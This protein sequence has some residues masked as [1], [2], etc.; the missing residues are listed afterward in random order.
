ML[1]SSLSFFTLELLEPF[2]EI[3][4][5][6]SEDAFPG[7]CW[8]FRKPVKPCWKPKSWGADPRRPAWTMDPARRSGL[9]SA[10][11]TQLSRSSRPGPVPAKPKHGCD[12]RPWV[13]QAA[14]P[15]CFQPPPS[16]SE[17]HG[18]AAC[19]YPATFNRSAQE[20]KSS[21]QAFRS[22]ALGSLCCFPF[23]WPQLLK[24]PDTWTPVA[25]LGS[26]GCQSCHPVAFGRG[27][28]EARGFQQQSLGHSWS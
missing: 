25:A 14:S 19:G 1:W 21:T 10:C 18:T 13:S 16:F 5:Q 15:P 26:P 28:H 11:G 8:S 3:T 12:A 20:S 17:L 2:Q 4:Q 23:C 27:C 9:L 6:Y 24:R 22:G 7:R